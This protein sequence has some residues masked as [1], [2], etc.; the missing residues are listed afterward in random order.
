MLE[1][2]RKTGNIQ[3]YL[4]SNLHDCDDRSRKVA[5]M[6]R[7]VVWA[8]IC[9]QLRFDPSQEGICQPLLSI[10]YPF[11][12]FVLFFLFLA[13]CPFSPD[14][15]FVSAD[16]FALFLKT[17]IVVKISNVTNFFVWEALWSNISG[18]KVDIKE[19]PP[20]LPLSTYSKLKN[21]MRDYGPHYNV[22]IAVLYFFVIWVVKYRWLIWLGNYLHDMYDIS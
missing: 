8:R 1:P 18:H 5:V 20:P 10:S 2:M 11:L 7:S 14:F 21:K 13:F 17:S 9:G 4:F 19:G 16:P 12:F 22:H 6:S 15:V 3:R